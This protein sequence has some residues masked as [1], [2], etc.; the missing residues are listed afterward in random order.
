MRR[1]FS[2]DLVRQVMN[3]LRE[4]EDFAGE[5]EEFYDPD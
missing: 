4:E 5:D 3:I 1:G 2:G